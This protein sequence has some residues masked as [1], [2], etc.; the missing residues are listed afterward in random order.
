MHPTAFGC[1]RAWMAT[2]IL[3]GAAI[4]PAC[5]LAYAPQTHVPDLPSEVELH[6]TM[7]PMRPTRGGKTD[8]PDRIMPGAATPEEPAPFPRP[9][10]AVDGPGMDEDVDEQDPHA[11]DREAIDVPPAARASLA[12]VSWSDA[13]LPAPVAATRRALLDAART[14]DIEALRPVFAAQS[15]QPVVSPM[16]AVDDPVAFLKDQ[17]GDRDGREILAILTEI[18]DSGHVFIT[19]EG[20][21]VWPYFAEVALDELK[22]PHYVELY[23]ILTSIDVEE[24]ERQGRYTFFRVGIGSDGRL[25][26]FAAGDLE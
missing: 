26:Y 14:G 10:D 18:L 22:A 16:V 3:A 20:T 6:A 17:S 2:A 19:D 1:L 5:S 13:T 25:R 23:R 15:R 8:L 9:E 4:F 11:A 21:Y 7:A 24:M 12:D